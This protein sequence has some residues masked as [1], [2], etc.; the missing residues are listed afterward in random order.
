MPVL[1]PVPFAEVTI[2]SP[3]W[4][5][6]LETVLTRTVPSQHAKLGES[7]ILESLTLPDPAAAAAHPAQP[8]RLHDAGVLGLRRRQVDRGGELR[9][10]PTAATPRSRRRSRRIVD[11]LERAQA[12]DGYLN[13]WYLG[14]EPENRFTNLRDNHELYN[15]G[16]LLE[17][18]IAYY[19]AT[20]RRR[21]LDILER[22]VDL[23]RRT[24]GTGPGQT[25]GYD[26]HQEIELALIKLYRLTGDRRHLD[27]AAYFID[28][29][30]QQPHYFDAEARARGDDPARFW[31]K[32][33]EYN[34]SHLP[35]RE[36]TRV[37][38]HAVRAMYMYSAMA[39]LARELGD[40]SLRRT[41]EVLWQDVI[42]SKM[43]V[44]GGLGPEAANEGFTAAYDLPNATAYAET[45][46]SVALVFWAQR[47][48]HFDLDGQYADVLERALF[49]NALCGLSRD[50]EH[51][52]Y[53]NPL[54]SDGTHRRWAW[55]HCPCCTMNAARLIASVGGYFLSH[56]DATVALH[57]YGGVTATLDLAGTR[58]QG[59][60]AGPLPLG[61][62]G[63]GQADAR[64]GRR[65]SACA[66]ASPAGAGPSRCR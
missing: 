40:D 36:Q 11:D 61:R 35:V 43:Y 48:L 64:S 26:G 42:A 56:D 2:T 54:E 27:L 63:P 39:D 7:G 16:H 53:A 45:C 52:Y 37:V 57:L 10:R 20:G 55:H 28:Q 23:V 22:Y 21:L 12:P 65:A 3:F 13:C 50:G 31:A 33:Y 47:M 15:L 1:A 29:R 59:R 58:G 44:T 9:A 25:R 41:C 62:R 18:G 19:R 17:G 66:C 4:R 24:F 14:H 38:G 6:R 49:N 51:Y 32:T 8:P 46:A 5:E 34:Q 60:G 30:G